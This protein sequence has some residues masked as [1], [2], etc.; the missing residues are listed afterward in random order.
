[1]INRISPSSTNKLVSINVKQLRAKL[2]LHYLTAS[3]ISFRKGFQYPLSIF[4]EFCVKP[5][6]KGPH[7]TL[8]LRDGS[9]TSFSFQQTPTS[10]QWA[11][12]KQCSR[13][14]QALHKLKK[15]H[16]DMLTDQNCEATAISY[17]G[18]G[19]LKVWESKSAVDFNSVPSATSAAVYWRKVPYGSHRHF[20]SRNASCG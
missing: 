5:G 6:F 17:N 20:C 18:V 12:F 10:T 7:S 2:I 4:A 14:V 9:L 16:N 8:V 15:I 1:M 19:P 13:L 11:F 3:M